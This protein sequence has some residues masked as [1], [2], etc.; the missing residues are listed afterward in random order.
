MHNLENA[1]FITAIGI[2]L[3]FVGIIFLWGLMALL[4]RLPFKQRSTTI[5]PT[6]PSAKTEQE[7]L[8]L[9]RQAVA[10]AIVAAI[11]L[12]NASLITS[13]HKVRETISPWQAGYRSRQL[14]QTSHIFNRKH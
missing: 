9:K 5:K 8:N 1:L 10:A 6:Q 3:V 13:A 12:Q 2:G 14:N 11:S 7:E 4:V